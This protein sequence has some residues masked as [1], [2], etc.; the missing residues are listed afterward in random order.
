MCA[1]RSCRSATLVALHPVRLHAR[2]DDRP[3]AVLRSQIEIELDFI[4]LACAF[5]NREGREAGLRYATEHPCAVSIRISSAHSTMFGVKWRSTLN[6][7]LGVTAPLPDDLLH[8]RY[9]SGQS[10]AGCQILRLTEHT[11]ARFASGSGKG[12]PTRV[13]AR[14]RSRARP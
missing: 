14:L 12:E 11:L 10:S 9:D 7:R 3:D 5:W 6:V 4:E 2:R 1:C 8:D 13:L